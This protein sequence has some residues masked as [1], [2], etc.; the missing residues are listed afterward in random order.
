MR[1]EA[2]PLDDN[3]HDE[4][5]DALEKIDKVIA[6]LA[7]E[8]KWCKFFAES[9]DRRRC[10]WGAMWVEDAARILDAPV[11][12]AIRQVTGQRHWCIDTFNDHPTTTHATVLEV[13]HQ[14][15]HNIRAAMPSPAPQYRWKPMQSGW[16]APWRTF[17]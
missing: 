15:R 1:E 3:R 11:L 2:M 8:D 9:S 10:L 5:S 13:L 17:P 14:A 6:L 7:T 4:Q 16:S 12:E